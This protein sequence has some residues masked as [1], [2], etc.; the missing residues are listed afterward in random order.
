M[1]QNLSNTKKHAMLNLPTTH[2]EKEEKKVILNILKYITDNI[3][4]FFPKIDHYF[5]YSKI[6]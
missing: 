4:F 5:S 2:W 1:M 3:N 6:F